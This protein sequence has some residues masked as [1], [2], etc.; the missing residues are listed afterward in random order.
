M[1]KDRQKSRLSLAGESTGL[2]RKLFINSSGT[3][4]SNP[5]MLETSLERDHRMTSVTKLGCAPIFQ[6]LIL[7]TT[8]QCRTVQRKIV[9]N[10][11]FCFA[12]KNLFISQFL[13]RNQQKT[14][15]F[16][17]II[18]HTKLLQEVC[19]LARYKVPNYQGEFGSFFELY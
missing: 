8:L 12:Q 7:I 17:Q 2:S 11:N 6:L 4:E 19:Q 16:P 3:E 5:L 10:S 18:F 13:L 1:G 14:L 15:H 9:K